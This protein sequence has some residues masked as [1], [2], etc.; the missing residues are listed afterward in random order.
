MRIQRIGTHDLLLPARQ[1]DGAAGYDLRA[2]RDY[3][4]D[5][6]QQIIVATGFAIKIPPGYVGLIQDRSSMAARK[7]LTVRAGVIDSDYRG[8]VSVVL[9]NEQPAGMSPPAIIRMGDR[10]AQMVVVPCYSGEP[11]EVDELP[12]TYRGDGGFGSTG[13]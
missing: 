5:P 12:A 4:I 10:I 1:T 7:R 9:C 6:G 3:R 8:E 13:T 11:Q 2:V